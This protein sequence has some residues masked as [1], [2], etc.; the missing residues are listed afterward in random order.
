[1]ISKEI[2]EVIVL[3]DLDNALL[4]KVVKFLTTSLPNG[5]TIWS[6]EHFIWKIVETS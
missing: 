3:D 2:W 6:K 5:D 4:E 1:M